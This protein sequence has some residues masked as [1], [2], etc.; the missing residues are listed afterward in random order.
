MKNNEEVDLSDF[1]F[2]NDNNDKDNID[3]DN[4]LS[5]K[6][7]DI[8]NPISKEELI[9]TDIAKQLK[10]TTNIN[11]YLWATHRLKGE[12][13]R[14]LADIVSEYPKEKIRKS[15]GAFFNFLVKKE[16]NRNKRE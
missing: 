13:L 10:D 3:N 15:R 6:N 4:L 16:I 12:T 2:D 5:N 7:I 9:A 8:D 11:F 1:G 14:R